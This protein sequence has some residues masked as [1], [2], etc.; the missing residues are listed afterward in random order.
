MKKCLQS[1]DFLQ[2]R[3]LSYPVKSGLWRKQHAKSGLFY[4][5]VGFW[6]NNDQDQRFHELWASKTQKPNSVLNSRL[7]IQSHDNHNYA[8][9]PILI[10]RSTKAHGWW[11]QVNN[12]CP[13]HYWI[14]WF[15]IAKS[16]VFWPPPPRVQ[17]QSLQSAV[18]GQ[19]RVLS[20]AFLKPPLGSRVNL[21]RVR[22]GAK[23][24][25]KVWSFFQT[26][27]RVQGHSLQ[28]AVWDLFSQNC[29]EFTPML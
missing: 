10:S 26:P 3:A 7:C 13:M 17:G 8:T 4:R 5:R 9:V 27:P 2:Y 28:S 11:P 23:I 29:L 19:N 18:L 6:R 21:C 14:K 20:L 12:S 24:G 25:C 1:L 22:F 16:G 15:W